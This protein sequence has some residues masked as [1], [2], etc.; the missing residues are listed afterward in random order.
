MSDRFYSLSSE[1]SV[2]DLVLTLYQVIT[3]ST[4]ISNG[5]SGV[6]NSSVNWFCPT[7]VLQGRRDAA[8]SP[9]V[10]NFLPLA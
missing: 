2:G 9:D 3:K 8:F 1:I 5:W 4:L 10:L 7:C 6:F